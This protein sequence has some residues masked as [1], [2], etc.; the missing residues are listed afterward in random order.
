MNADDSGFEFADGEFNFVKLLIL[1]LNI[2]VIL[3]LLRFLNFFVG[4]CVCVCVRTRMQA[5]MWAW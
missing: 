3:R 4:E 5:H 2:Q 1:F